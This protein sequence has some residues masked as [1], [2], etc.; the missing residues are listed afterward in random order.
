MRLP[1]RSKAYHDLYSLFNVEVHLVVGYEFLVA[2]I[3]SIE[4]LLVPLL[5]FEQRRRCFRKRDFQTLNVLLSF[6]RW[7]LTARLVLEQKNKR[8]SRDDKLEGR[9]FGRLL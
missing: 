8:A 2:A 6:C 5:L 9:L 3:A 4:G 7:C 1:H